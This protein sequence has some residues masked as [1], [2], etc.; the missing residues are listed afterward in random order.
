[1]ISFLNEPQKLLQRDQFILIIANK[2]QHLMSHVDGSRRNEDVRQLF[3]YG[4]R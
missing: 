4:C 2:N 1:M 3:Y